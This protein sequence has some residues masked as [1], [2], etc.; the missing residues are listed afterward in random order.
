MKP[1]LL[2][3]FAG[4]TWAADKSAEPQTPMAGATARNVIYRDNDIVPVSVAVRYTTLIRLPPGEKV[5]V[6]MCGDQGANW[7]VEKAENYV[8][9]TPYKVGAETNVNVITETGH[10]YTFLLKEVGAHGNPDLK[11]FISLSDAK[12]LESNGKPMFVSVDAIEAYKRE[13]DIAK[14]T[15]AMERADQQLKLVQQKAT[16]R[17][18][19]EADIK[20]D[21]V[22]DHK[23]AEKL[24]IKAIW[25]DKQFTHVE[26]TAQET[27]ALYEVLDGKDTLIE[28]QQI[29]GVYQV[30]KI[31]N[32]GVLRLGRQKLSF[33]LEKS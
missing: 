26:A 9:I 15:L 3:C 14:A 20:H 33:R 4:L 2:L 30:P 11:V 31:V 22:Y 8:V 25:H 7:A 6:S 16:A 24:G 27:P 23:E 13:A 29:N 21:Y 28:Y 1:L 17:S 18:E 5:L 19:A 12:G 32:A 10:P